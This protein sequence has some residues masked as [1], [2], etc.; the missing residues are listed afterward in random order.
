MFPLK[1]YQEKV[2][3]TLSS[4]LAA[5]GDAQEKEKRQN[6]T[7]ADAGNET[8][9]EDWPKQGW[10][11]FWKGRSNVEWQ[12]CVDGCGRPVPN[13]CLKIPTGGGK[14][15][16]GVHAVERI[17]GEFFRRNNGLVLWI[18][19]SEAIYSQTL[20]NFRDPEHPCRFLLKRAAA[21]NSPRVI[22]RTD[23]F[24]RLDVDANLTV[25]LLTLQAG[26]VSEGKKEARK[27]HNE[28][29]HHRDI[30]PYPDRHVQHDALLEEFPN[31]DLDAPGS[32]PATKGYVR[33][34]L[35]N[36]I[37]VLRPIVV[38][39][40]SQNVATDIRREFV[41]SLNPRFILELSAT[42]ESDSNLLVNVPGQAL[43]NEEM[44]KLPINLYNKEQ[45]DWKGTLFRAT[46]KLRELDEKAR[47]LRRHGNR[48]IRPI[49]LIQAEQTGRAQLQDATRIHAEHVRD[50]LVQK[51]NFRPDEVRVKSAEKNEIKKENLLAETSPVRAIITKAALREG[52]DCSFAYVLA[53][54]AKSTRLGA[55]L[56][57]LTGR[58]L[59]QP[60]ATL[61]GVDDLDEAHVFCADQNVGEAVKKVQ[62]C[63]DREGLGDVNGVMTRRD[64]DTGK[65]NLRIPVPRRLTFK[66]VTVF[67]PR[68]LHGKEKRGGKR[69]L[70][71]ERD[72]LFGLPWED[73]SFSKKHD[74]V[75]QQRLVQGAT[76]TKIYPGGSRAM[77]RGMES[78]GDR[79]A[80]SAFFARGLS[81]S[82]PNPWVAA[83]IASDA[84][85]AFDRRGIEQEKIYLEREDIL[86]EMKQDITERIDEASEALF[87]AKLKSGDLVFNLNAVDDPRLRWEAEKTMNL[88]VVKGSQIFS[89]EDGAPL[90][91]SLYDRVFSGELNGLEKDFAFYLEE[92]ANQAI[93]YWHRFAASVVNGCPLQGWRKHKIYPDFLACIH[94][95]KGIRTYAILETKGMYLK[96]EDTKYKEKIFAFLEQAASQADD[97]GKIT[98]S[99]NDGKAMVLRILMENNWKQKMN[100]LTS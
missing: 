69:L 54:L 80:D 2:L 1:D 4:Y 38:I 24:A 17:N 59:R 40:E 100:T 71:Y 86:D 82:V 52:W 13:I 53:L 51:L 9:D 83:G 28:S 64:D 99:R 8:L 5:L 22:E 57:Q 84:L 49:M 98:I 15:L 26:A 90:Q 43:K 32:S 33:H 31:L 97:T 61:T 37:R 89:R 72:I 7:L 78:V 70:D 36:A 23:R 76:R 96:N 50:Y 19:P 87:R 46:E 73:F 41:S 67:L 14:T 66:D 6:K 55:G 20:K 75:F 11:S 77:G 18:V 60:G 34:S 88:H 91:L 92:N 79:R 58:V 68:I 81:G 35:A 39:D 44:I 29:G 48:Y 47:K 3:E 30:L 63:L 21:H 94:K 56:T 65:D 16:L 25:M 10:K 95:K 12:N 62:E 27:F 74:R 93:K 85:K 45:D 42:P